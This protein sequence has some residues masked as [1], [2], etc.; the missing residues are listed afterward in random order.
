MA[1]VEVEKADV[2]RS[3]SAPQVSVQ[4][5]PIGAVSVQGTDLRYLLMLHE[6]LYTLVDSYTHRPSMPDGA[7]SLDA[8]AVHA[9]DPTQIRFVATQGYQTVT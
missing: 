6:W 1:P 3:H 4:C 2:A 8:R 5:S 7:D 9:H